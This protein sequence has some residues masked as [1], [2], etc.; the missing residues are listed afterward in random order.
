ME[1]FFSCQAPNFLTR[2]TNETLFSSLHGRA[3]ALTRTSS[4]GLGSSEAGPLPVASGLR[5]QYRVTTPKLP[6]PPP[7]CAHH[8]SRL[9]SSASR[10]ATTLRALPL[11]STTTTSTAY[12]WS[13]VRP[14]R[15]D[16]MP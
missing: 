4:G 1:P 7:V 16:S 13:T 11:A 15:L 3:S 2:D 14:C 5:N 6:P 9:G 10:V 12:R 8:R